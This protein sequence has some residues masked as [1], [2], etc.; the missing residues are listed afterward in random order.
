MY[1][2]NNIKYRTLRIKSIG[3]LVDLVLIFF[4]DP[5]YNKA[6]ISI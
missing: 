2:E 4:M 6:S 1:I 3:D 5:N